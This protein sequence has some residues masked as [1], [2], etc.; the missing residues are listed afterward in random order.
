LVV[1]LAPHQLHWEI[2]LGHTNYRALTLP[3]IAVLDESEPGVMSTTT[4]T[5][6]YASP[7]TEM[8]ERTWKVALLTLAGS[9]AL[10]PLATLVA[11]WTIRKGLAP[12]A[13]LARGAEAVSASNW[14][15]DPPPSATQTV[16]LIPLTTAMETMLATL[17]RAFTSQREFLANAA[18]EFKTPVTVLKSTL[19]CMQQRP[20]TAEEYREAVDSVLE[21]IGR[22]EKLI[23][24]MLRLA[25]AEQAAMDGA[26]GN[27]PPL[28]LNDSCAQ[29][30]DRLRALAEAGGIT[31]ELAAANSVALVAADPE[32]LEMVWSNLLEN[33][34]RYSDRGARVLVTVVEQAETAIV[35]VQD[36]GAGIPAADLP[37]I[38]DRFR[39]ADTSRTRATGGYGLGLAIA[40][41]MVESYRGTIAAQSGDGAGTVMTV[42]LQTCGDRKLPEPES[43]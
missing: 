5:V 43:A 31:V 41:A 14:R 6:T 34:I 8:R 29:A 2:T 35:T 16:E 42:R 3:R 33:A 37:Y 27:C 38:F 32:D 25:R 9:G 18:H 26:K 15:L 23:H 30:I 11:V 28:D 19:Q 24:S 1:P 12:L 13:E 20:R 10:L 7:T 17:H 22:L 21:D 4:L 36:W 40:K 39:R